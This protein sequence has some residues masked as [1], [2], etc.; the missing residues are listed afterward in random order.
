MEHMVVALCG[1]GQ[2]VQHAR[3]FFYCPKER[4]T[5]EAK[6]KPRTQKTNG[7]RGWPQRTSPRAIM[8]ELRR[9]RSE[10]LP[11]RG[12]Q[13]AGES[14]IRNLSK[15]FGDDGSDGAAE[16]TRQWRFASN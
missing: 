3:S 9:P 16:V 10:D 11:S 5:L 6:E 12:V 4:E 13:N 8:E 7:D 1:L 15:G 2:P 14:R